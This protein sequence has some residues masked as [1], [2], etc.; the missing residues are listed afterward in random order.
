MENPTDNQKARVI[1][2]A[3]A[4]YTGEKHNFDI[5]IDDNPEVHDAPGSGGCWVAAWVFVADANVDVNDETG[6][7]Y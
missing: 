4:I 5:E 6:E 3:R 7:D 2:F 1:A